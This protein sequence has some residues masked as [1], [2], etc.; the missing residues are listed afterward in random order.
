MKHIRLFEG[1]S[2]IDSICKK[3]GITNYTIN[4]DGNVDVDGNV[5]LSDKGL[6]KLPLKFGKVS[7]HFYCYS[8]QLES[9]EGGP[10]EV[11]RDFNCCSNNYLTTLEGGPSKVGGGFDCRHNQLT[12]LEGCPSDVGGNFYCNGNKLTTLEGCPS[13]VGGSFDCSNNYLTTLEGGPSHVGGDFDCRYNR[14]ITLEGGPSHV[15]RDFYCYNNPIHQVYILFKNYNSFKDS[16][17]YNYLRGTDIVKSRF[18][19]A[20]EESGIEIPDKIEGYRY[21]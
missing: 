4:S 13:E 3:Y 21:I 16:L 9:L 5:D 19:E 17:D 7:G 6:S 8:N 10:I 11:G 20:C 1:F 12:T 15:G 2:N 18:K 14:L